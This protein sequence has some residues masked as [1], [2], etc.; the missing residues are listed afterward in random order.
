MR[1]DTAVNDLNL[2]LF[3][4]S[5]KSTLNTI[6]DVLSNFQDNRLV[7]IELRDLYDEYLG[8][9]QNDVYDKAYGK[10]SYLVLMSKILPD[11]KNNS[12][13]LIELAKQAIVLDLIYNQLVQ[14]NADDLK[15]LS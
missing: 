3:G 6:D 9:I 15:R 4:K 13:Y 5:T 11:T 8:K 12:A 14:F 2:N 10:L 1:I 7:S